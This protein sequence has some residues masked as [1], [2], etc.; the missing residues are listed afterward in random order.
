MFQAC[1]RRG[2]TRWLGGR[3]CPQRDTGRN[4]LEAGGAR[5][6]L[7]KWLSEARGRGLRV[8]RP[9][10]WIGWMRSGVSG[11]LV[12][13][14]FVSDMSGGLGW[15]FLVVAVSRVAARILRAHGLL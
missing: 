10:L 3:Y 6:I 11:V 15:F 1:K 14:W 5:R 7:G 2:T 12:M 8:T 9:T 4:V 13:M